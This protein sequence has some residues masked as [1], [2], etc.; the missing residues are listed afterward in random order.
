M[1]TTL[2][3]IIAIALLVILG[4]NIFSKKAGKGGLSGQKAASDSGTSSSPS[5]QG[6][7]AL[8]E[9]AMALSSAKGVKG[10]NM[11]N[12]PPEPPEFTGRKELLKDI[13]ARTTTR[14]TL[15]GIHGFS[16]VGK[17][18]LSIALIKQFAPQ[19]PGDCLFMD[20]L[21]EQPNPPSAED[22]M[23]RIILRFHPS[24]PLPADEIKLAK[25]YRV[26]LKKHRGILILDNA[27]SIKQVKSLVPPSS[28]LLIV[29]SVKPIAL[30]KM[31]NIELEPM[32]SLEAH[33]LLTRLAPEISPAIKDIA[34]IC[35]GIPLSLELI[36]K[37]FAINST[38]APDYFAKKFI[39]AREKLGSIEEEDK[40][41]SL[42]NG[43]RTALNLSYHMLPEKTVLIF[44]KLSVFPESFTANAATFICED[45]KNLT[46]IGLVKFGLVQHN[47]RTD[48]FSM[49]DQIK[50][51]IKPML[52]PSVRGMTEKR[53]A[54]E[55]MNVLET[56]SFHIEKGGKETIKGLRL[57][58]LELENIKAGMRWSQKL[59]DKDK[60]AARICSAYTENGATLISQRLSP[61]ECLQWFEAGLSAAR[62]LEDHEAE[63]KHLLNLGQQHVLLNQ[64]QKAIDTLQRALTL[65]KKE[66]AM[67]GQRTA[68]RLLGQICLTSN[69]YPLA[70]KYLEEDLELVRTSGNDDEEFK[71]L[72]QLTQSCTQNKEHNKA[73]HTGEQALDL[74]EPDIH[75]TLQITLLYNLGQSYLE[76]GENKQAIQRLE[77]GLE[78]SQK[79]PDSPLLAE[80][81]KLVGETVFKSGDIAGA[82]KYLE[83][84]LEALRKVKALSA[85]GTLMIQLA[86]IHIHNK[87]EE[88]A[89]QYFEE[90]LILAQNIKDRG[91]EGQILWAWSQ[92][93][94]EKGSLDEAII[95]GQKALKIYEALKKPEA[96]D[97]RG[98]I[99]N[100]SK[101]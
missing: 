75:K 78:I 15:I 50:K 81:F 35:K 47:I 38:M 56:A 45:P 94:G 52:T 77:K 72:A 89:N 46:L 74:A 48:R 3:I 86:E 33:T 97:I 83:K 16:G 55:F 44:R 64:S 85:Q 65:C 2:I 28:W 95:R 60:D 61:A 76:I 79:T 29:T 40:K 4:S 42:I 63:R 80:L 39:E 98:K 41:D 1:T 8:I 100:W 51:F 71:L 30:P 25:L 34:P 66:G 17:T 54:T 14:P 87:N 24:Q 22:I 91:M 12:P 62:Q 32:E 18:C 20:M 84:G 92:A 23:R 13:M 7:E 36:G 37:L 43:V 27:A 68:L 88:R 101:T 49:H 53:L 11:F 26:A 31:V 5:K 73:I 96:Q 67:E 82:L 99:E 58:D 90:A 6:K 69:D 59:C 19:F 9:K 57:F 93:L 10:E 21:G 70:T